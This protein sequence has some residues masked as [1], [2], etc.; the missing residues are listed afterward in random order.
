MLIMV[1]RMKVMMMVSIKM[2]HTCV[3]GGVSGCMNGCVVDGLCDD[4]HDSVCNVVGDDL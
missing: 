2:C 1:V 4:V 3:N